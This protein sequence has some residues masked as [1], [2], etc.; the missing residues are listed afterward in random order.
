MPN[1]K[2]PLSDLMSMQGHVAYLN[3]T[4]GTLGGRERSAPSAPR[5]L[6]DANRTG[7]SAAATRPN[8]EGLIQALMARGMSRAEATAKANR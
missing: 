8:K 4:G 2:R 3:A 5:V 1:R 7:L 6:N